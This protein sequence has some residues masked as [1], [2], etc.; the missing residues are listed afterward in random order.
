MPPNGEGVNL[1]ML[2][3]L[4]LAECLNSFTDVQQALAACEQRMFDH[5]EPICQETIEGNSDF[6][7]PTESAVQELIK[8]L[9]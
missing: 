1:A 9:S 2:D 4:D 3:A 5:A 6:A 8:M 7:A